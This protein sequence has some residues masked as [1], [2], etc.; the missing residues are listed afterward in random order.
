L[1][2]RYK[3]DYIVV[4]AKNYDGLVGKNDVLQIGNYLKQHGTGLFGLIV[5][6][7]GEDSSSLETRKEQWTT[8]DKLIIILTDDE[9]KAMLSSNRPEEIIKQKI[10]DFRLDL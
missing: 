9:I 3:G 7:Q 8:Y 5:T 10:E 6:R 4:D 1:R 2:H